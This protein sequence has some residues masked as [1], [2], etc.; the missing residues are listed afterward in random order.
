[1]G[2]YLANLA[3]MTFYSPVLLLVERERGE[4]RRVA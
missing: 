4:G 1:M 2:L 3:T